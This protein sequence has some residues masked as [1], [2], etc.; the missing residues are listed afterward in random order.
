ME[1]K[2]IQGLPSKETDTFQPGN[3]Q[4]IKSCWFLQVDQEMS[5]IFG[6][7]T[8][9]LYSGFFSEPFCLFVCPFDVRVMFKLAQYKI[10]KNVTVTKTS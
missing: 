4:A 10:F 7:A 6:E 5:W 9:T 1:V 2:D 3:L 8:S